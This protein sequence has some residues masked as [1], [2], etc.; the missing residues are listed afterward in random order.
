[1]KPSKFNVAIATHD[2]ERI[3]I[4]NTLYRT[5][6]I[7][8]RK[9]LHFLGWASLY[10]NQSSIADIWR[11]LEGDGPGILMKGENSSLADPALLDQANKLKI[12]VENELDEFSELDHFLSIGYRPDMFCPVVALTAS[13]NL[14]CVYCF[15]EG[16]VKRSDNMT[17]STAKLT[18]NWMENYIKNHPELKTFSLGLFGGEPLL[19][20]D[21]ANFFIDKSKLL[22]ERHNLSFSFGLTTNGTK[23]TR[24][25]VDDWV[26]RGLTF[27]RVTLDGPK[28]IH[29]KRRYYRSKSKGGTFDHI[30]SNLINIG[31][32]TGFELEIEVNIDVENYRSINELL[33]VLE[34]AGLKERIGVVPEQTL[35]SLSS[36]GKKSGC[37][38]GCSHCDE[39]GLTTDRQAWFR[40]NTLVE[41]NL[42]EAFVYVVDQIGRRGF[43]MPEMV[44]VY[45]PCIFVQR[46]HMVIDWYGDIYKCSF[47]LGNQDMRVGNIREGFNSNNQKML[48]S[49][50]TIEWCK[51]RNCAYIPICGGG[52]RYEAYNITGSYSFPN[53]KA[54]L[55]DA[56]L[57]RTVPYFF[58]TKPVSRDYSPPKMNTIDEKFKRINALKVNTT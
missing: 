35:E 22:A 28:S 10:Q 6:A 23:L 18:I 30:L 55:I 24:E 5:A 17:K 20:L 33:D 49:I 36:Q 42:T 53:C 56:V 3:L 1:M 52:C 41:T 13:C 46:H 48:D 43:N 27:I 2:P 38:G 14:D 21:S 16:A 44:G 4:Y 37:V 40:R 58:N 32:I 57:P 8:P 7:F 19:S 12:M 54:D 47:T 34:E 9:A 26:S 25:L 15:E 11:S 39:G 50:K 31:D 51:S 45:Y 29:D